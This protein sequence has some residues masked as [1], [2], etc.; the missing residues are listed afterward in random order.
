MET[1]DKLEMLKE[2]LEAMTDQVK[3]MAAALST[4][5]PCDC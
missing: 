4:P 1:T 5:L 2:Q 3:K